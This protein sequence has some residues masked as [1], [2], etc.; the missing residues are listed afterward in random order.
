MYTTITSLS[1]LVLF[2]IFTYAISR[3]YSFLILVF[4]AKHFQ[5]LTFFSNVQAFLSAV[6]YCIIEAAKFITLVSSILSQIFYYS[7]YFPKSIGKFVSE[8]S[9][10]RV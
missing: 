5:N 6:D 7:N 1:I 3:E 10:Y 9:D 2:I 8:A 4:N